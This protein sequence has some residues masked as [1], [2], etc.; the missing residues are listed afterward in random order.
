MFFYPEFF[1]KFN[2]G[3][4]KNIIASIADSSDGKRNNIE[5]CS[6]ANI[7]KLE[8]K[9]AI[10][11]SRLLWAIRYIKNLGSYSRTSSWQK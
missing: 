2:S 10:F 7:L 6:R 4:C 9:Y 8:P 3:D 5:T 11:K 1:N